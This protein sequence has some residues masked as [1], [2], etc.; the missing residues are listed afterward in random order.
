MEQVL[1][2][3][4]CIPTLDHFRWRSIWSTTLNRGNFAAGP[5]NYATNCTKS[6]HP[7]TVADTNVRIL[8]FRDRLKLNSQF[9][10]HW[11][12]NTC[13]KLHLGPE[14][15][16]GEGEEVVDEV[17]YSSADLFFIRFSDVT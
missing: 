12:L 2:Q 14:I 6:D 16:R 5:P 9:K 3:L 17:I 1:E 4:I 13:Q 15:K 7:G 11:A 8:R 10:N